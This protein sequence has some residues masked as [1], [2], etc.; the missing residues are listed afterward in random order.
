MT[1]DQTQ[2]HD[3]AES[4]A[5][6]E[7]NGAPMTASGRGSHAASRPVDANPDAT[8]PEGEQRVAGDPLHDTAHPESSEQIVK[9]ARAA[10]PTRRAQP[11][12]AT[13]DADPVAA[14]SNRRPVRRAAGV[15]RQQVTETGPSDKSTPGDVAAITAP[16]AALRPRRRPE[17]GA[18][19]ATSGETSRKRVNRRQRSAQRPVPTRDFEQERVSPAVFVRQSVGELRKV[20]WPS[21]SQ[22]GEYFVVVLAFVLFIIAFVGLLDLFFGWG[23]LKLLGK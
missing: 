16:G 21:G 4:A 9:Q 17:A 22:L 8:A 19:L 6:P 23:L 3:D 10:R 14:A 20:V 15:D 11:L 18:E 5:T 2:S 7:S 12:A 1:D 13:E